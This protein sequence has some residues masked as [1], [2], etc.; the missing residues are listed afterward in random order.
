MKRLAI[1]FDGGHVRVQAKRS[2]KMYSASLIEKVAHAACA[3]DEEIY[4]ILYYDCEQYSG[5]AKLPVSG[6][7]RTFT[8]H[9][10]LLADLCR[11][12]LFA[13]RKGVLKFEDS[14]LSQLQ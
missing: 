8:P 1:L 4:R 10:T 5:T 6:V 11:K 7:E 14:S 12:Q 9:S 13:V 2:G 3:T